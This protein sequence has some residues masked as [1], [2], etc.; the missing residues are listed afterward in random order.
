MVKYKDFRPRF[1]WDFFLD[2][3]IND[4]FK[5]RGRSLV[6]IL[7]C[8]DVS[9]VIYT[10]F[11]FLFICC[12]SQITCWIPQGF[13]LLQCRLWESYELTTN[14]LEVIAAICGFILQ[15]HWTGTYDWKILAFYSFFAL[16]IK[17]CLGV[18]QVKLSQLEWIISSWLFSKLCQTSTHF[19]HLCVGV[20]LCFGAL[21]LLFWHLRG[22]SILCKLH[23]DMCVCVC[24]YTQVYFIC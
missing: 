2:L 22:F 11:S 23:A 6:Y 17:V 8:I 10:F 14:C 1:G 18:D 21:L 7:D 24:V 20:C 13:S 4:V 15:R 9:L 3:F 5:G 16:Y 19:S 12:M